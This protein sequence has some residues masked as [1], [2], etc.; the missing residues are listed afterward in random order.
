MTDV[1]AHRDQLAGLREIFLANLIMTAEIP[2]PT[3]GEDVRARFMLQRFSEAGLPGGSLDEAGNAAVVLPGS[4]PERH[5]L[6][7]AHTDTVHAAEI[8]HAVAVQP[9]RVIG[10]GIGDN[11]AGVAAVITLPR[12]LH[13]L[14]IELRSTLVLL[15]AGRSLGHGNLD[16][17]RF[18]L[19]HA[20][21]PIAAGICV[22]GVELGRLSH[23]SIGMLRGEIVCRVPRDYDWTRFGAAGA[24]AMINEVVLG[25]QGIPLPRRPRTQ[26][27]LGQISGGTAF[28]RVA[29]SARLRFEVQSECATTLADIERRIQDI[30]GEIQYRMRATASLD[31]VARRDPGGLPF[32]H[33]HVQHARA[34]LQALGV[35]P[36]IAPSTS[37]LSAFIHRG[38][39]ALTV[40]LS[41]GEN[42]GE[43]NESVFIDPC[44]A[45][46]AQLVA[47][48]QAVDGGD[49]DE[50]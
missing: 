49:D 17:L 40:G 36:R 32:T 37:E 6:V 1:I 48:L 35:E 23:A 44:F 25:I 28:N 20:A 34:I 15:G 45:G 5:V 24:I 30:L 50:S 38:I 31:V 29:R 33:P 21:F 9:D 41:R 14:G 46:L 22:E 12:I 19:E 8:D 26:I 11:S 4:D 13:T 18:F 27:V 10:P 39:P 7:V 47:L 3:F 16:G 2:A 43:P 42:I